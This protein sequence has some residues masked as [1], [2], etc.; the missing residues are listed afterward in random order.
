MKHFLFIATVSII[1]NSA[2]LA[3]DDESKTEIAESRGNHD[4]LLNHVSKL[5]DCFDEKD[6]IMANMTMEKHELVEKVYTMESSFKELNVSRDILCKCFDQTKLH[7]SDNTKNK[8]ELV[9]KLDEMQGNNDA[10]KTEVAESKE[11][12]ADLLKQVK[13]LRQRLDEKD[14]SMS[15]MI[16]EKNELLVEKVAETQVLKNQLQ[17]DVKELKDSHAEELNKLREHL[18]EKGTALSSVTMEKK[19]LVDKLAKATGQKNRTESEIQQARAAVAAAESSGVS[20]RSDIEEL[21][22]ENESLQEQLNESRSSVSEE[23]QVEVVPLPSTSSIGFDDVSTTTSA[24]KV[25]NGYRGLDWENFRV[26]HRSFR[27]STGCEYGIVSGNYVAY[28]HLASPYS[29]SSATPFS[30]AGFQATAVGN[31]GLNVLVESFDESGNRIGRYQTTLG[32]PRNG[33]SFIDLRREGNFEGLY[34]LK[35]T[36]SGGTNAG[37]GRTNSYLAIDNMQVY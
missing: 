28:N 7:S 32:D 14:N 10:L 36:P 1:G 26:A 37:L 3:I 34:K 20:L 27:P 2:S 30:V 11:N 21:R 9:E 16:M 13:K 33:P 12:Q 4:K 18:G 19:D 8:R 15:N 29:I 5:P 25:L 6:K 22:R 17:S 35:I 23:Q 31:T 24:A